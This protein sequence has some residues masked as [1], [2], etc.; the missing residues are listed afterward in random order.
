MLGT[1]GTKS[2]CDPSEPRSWVPTPHLNQS[3][4]AGPV[5][6]IGVAKGSGFHS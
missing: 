2:S 1:L 4:R 6:A 3:V 5:S